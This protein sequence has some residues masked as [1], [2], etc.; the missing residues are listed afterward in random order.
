VEV[1][2]A[3]IRALVRC[4][5]ATPNVFAALEALTDDPVPAVRAE[6]VIG[7]ARLKMGRPPADPTRSARRG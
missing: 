4:Q 2:K 5:A 6:A 7:Q 1:R 3:C